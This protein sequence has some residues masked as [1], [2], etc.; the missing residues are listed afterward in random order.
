MILKDFA[1]SF[2]D[3]D[4]VI[5][6]PIY[7]AREVD[8]GTISSAILSREINQN[9]NNSKSFDNFEYTESYLSGNLSTMGDKDVIITMGAGEAS[10]IGDFLLK[11]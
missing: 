3:A 7:Y 4:E 1:K 8:D 5:L 9:T 11:N 6:L 2:N 10:K